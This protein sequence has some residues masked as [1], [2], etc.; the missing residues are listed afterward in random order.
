MLKTPSDLLQTLIQIPSVTPHECGIYNLILN[1]FHEANFEHSIIRQEKGGVHNLFLLFTPK[2][3]KNDMT[4]QALH[5]PY[6]KPNEDFYSQ[7][8][9]KECS[10]SDTALLATHS[11]PHFCFA[12]HVDVV[13]TGDG[14]TYPPF[15]GDI[16]Q[17][18]GERYI[19]GRGAQDMKG[20]I[21]AFICALRDTFKTLDS[22]TS[23]CVF[24]ILLTSDEEGEGIYG[25]RFML[26][27]LAKLEILPT[28]C[29][30]A[31]PTS[32]NQSG[33]MIKIGRRGSINGIL[34]IYG[35]QGH[36]AYPNKCLN[37]IECLGSHLGKLAG[38]ELD[39]GNA[40]FE[41]SKLVITDIRGGMEVVNVTP[42]SLKIMFNI[43]NSPLSSLQSIRSYIQNVL[44]DMNVEEFTQDKQQGFSYKLTLKTSSQPFMTNIDSVLLTLLRASIMQVGKIEAN[45]STTGGTSDA[46]FFAAHQVEVVELGVPNDRIHALDERVNERDLFALYEIFK[47]FLHSYIMNAKNLSKTHK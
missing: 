13:P 18:G 34:E 3:F 31:E 37:P 12:G 5:S 2:V 14:W 11:L 39:S 4:S 40:H 19:Y 23:P 25:T 17:E 43:R 1:E 38:V 30:V 47:D 46:R 22:Q 26:E 10:F 28:H 20:G 15:C 36:V 42:N 9:L 44:Q 33:D 45:L 16:I 32:Q 41:P 8:A 24:S 35:K 21:S 27:A 7:F 6:S 29:I